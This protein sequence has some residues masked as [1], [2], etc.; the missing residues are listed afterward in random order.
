M[1]GAPPPTADYYC[2]KAEEIRR[3][4]RHASAAEIRLELFEL[5]EQF[6]RMAERVERRGRAG[7]D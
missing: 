7:L 6:E 1:T 2:E 4:A 3:F 5:A